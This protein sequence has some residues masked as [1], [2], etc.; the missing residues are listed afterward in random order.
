MGTSENLLAAMPLW[1]FRPLLLAA[2]LLCCIVGARLRRRLS[3]DDGDH[4]PESYL[5]SAVLGL[6]GLMIA[7][8]FSMALTR[9]DHRREL[10]IDEANAIG[11][12][13]LRA[14]LL[15]GETGQRLQ[16]HI[17]AYGDLRARLPVEIGRAHV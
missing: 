10:V 15:P 11:T 8:T 17:R 4:D 3:A 12:A 14:G 7:F 16:Q 1:L 9:Y 13:W 2:F 5:L 6:L